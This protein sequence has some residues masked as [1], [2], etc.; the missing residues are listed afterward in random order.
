MYVAIRRYDVV[1]PG[2]VDDL[3]QQA[4]EG[5]VPIMK[6]AP[7][8]QAYYLINTGGGTVTSVSVFED[9]AGA[10][11]SNRLAADWVGENLADKVQG[12]PEITAGEVR[13]HAAAPSGP[14]GAV[15]DT[16]GG[17]TGTVGGAAGTV[18]DTAGGLLGG[19]SKEE[20]DK[21]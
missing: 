3:L 2:S 14:V 9:Q 18:T 21:S 17:V 4:E 10:E 12:P 19:G 16:V 15:T 11:E 1:D 7:G 6:D 13:A 20:R 8:F 5:L